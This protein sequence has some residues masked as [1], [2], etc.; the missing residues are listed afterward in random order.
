MD[1]MQSTRNKLI[2]LLATSD[3]QYISGQILS[4]KLN[5][6]RSAIWKHM[7]TLEKEGF[8]IEGKPK[9]GYRIVQF[10][11]DLNEFSLKKGL[12]TEW[13]GKTIIYQDVITSTQH[14]AHE[15]AQKQADHGTIVVASEQT[16]G[17]GRL[18]REW[19]SPN[20]KGIWLSLILRPTIFPYLAPQLT[21]L[22]ATV[23]AEVI[24]SQTDLNPKIKWPNDLLIQDRK[25]AGILTEMKAE[26]DQ[27]EYLVIGIGLNVNIEKED[28]PISLQSKATSLNIETGKKWE[29]IPLIQGILQT[30]EQEYTAYLDKGFID[31]KQKWERFGYKIGQNVWITTANDRWQAVFLGIAE[32]GALLMRTA[33]HD[34]QKVYS[35]EIKWFS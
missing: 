9:L 30:F 31:V 26:Q 5:I 28:I 25:V 1:N 23:L 15:L 10:P 21:L 17:K 22:T 2:H 33:E 12:D 24:K 29:I 11:D 20:G 14:L 7:K 3:D 13:I 27:I 4:Q 8:K 16:N 34:I 19:Y 35:A 32:D 18:A 6:T